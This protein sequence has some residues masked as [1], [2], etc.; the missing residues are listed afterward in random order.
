MHSRW[1]VVTLTLLA[2]CGG[3]KKASDRGGADPAT[4]AIASKPREPLTVPDLGLTIDVPAGTAIS[5]PY[6]PEDASRMAHLE[7]GKFMVNL[8]AVGDYSVQSFARAKEIHRDDKLLDW[9]SAEETPTGWITF[10]HVVSSIPKAPRY[11]VDV[12]TYIGGRGW[13]CAISAETRALA[14]LTLE[15]CKTLR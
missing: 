15:A 14:E 13:D 12:R 4:R 7:Q 10:K 6:R 8:S 2:A 9:I 3:D 5:P 11:E 1:F